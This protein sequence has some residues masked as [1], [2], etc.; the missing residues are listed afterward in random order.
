MAVS[1]GNKQVKE[2]KPVAPLSELVKRKLDPEIWGSCGARV[3]SAGGRIVVIGCE[4]HTVDDGISCEFPF[5]DNGPKNG[6][7]LIVAPPGTGGTMREVC[8]TCH[9]YLSLKPNHELRGGIMDWVKEEGEEIS[10]KG[11]EK[12]DPLKPEA[13]YKDVVR[14]EVIPVHK[15]L[16]DN[17][18]MVNA[19]YESKLREEH[20]NR[21]RQKH[22]AKVMGQDAVTGERTDVH[23]PEG[24]EADAGKPNRRASK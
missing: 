9:T 21:Q 4:H 13:G 20:A 18:E 7:V 8:M 5:K 19:A 24:L 10:V 14:Q 1:E 11:S 23:T 6:G 3:K 2:W 16:D 17:L 22:I 15:H 12:N